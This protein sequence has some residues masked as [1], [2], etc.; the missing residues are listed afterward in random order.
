[1]E[2]A[3]VEK[4]PLSASLKEVIQADTLSR[5]LAKVKPVVPGKHNPGGMDGKP[6][7]SA[8]TGKMA[9]EAKAALDT[10]SD[11]AY[12]GMLTNLAIRSMDAEQTLL[13][14]G[15]QFTL[16]MSMGKDQQVIWC[17]AKLNDWVRHWTEKGKAFDALSFRF[18]QTNGDVQGHQ[19]HGRQGFIT[20]FFCGL[21]LYPDQADLLQKR[22]GN[23]K[24]SKASKRLSKAVRTYN[25]HLEVIEYDRKVRNG[26]IDPNAEPEPKVKAEG[27]GEAGDEERADVP[28]DETQSERFQKP[29]TPGQ[30]YRAMYF[31]AGDRKVTLTG[32]KVLYYRDVLH[33][34]CV[35][36][37]G[38]KLETIVKWES[39][40]PESS[41]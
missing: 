16:Y 38:A 25:E 30:F 6:I 11:S 8:A 33:A 9:K 3:I 34:L 39:E 22:L 29:N 28:V 21:T 40:A 1:M 10:A 12:Q 35:E 13:E 32:G 18:I 20:A 36:V 7:S 31:A 2:T 41:K 26:E 37:S 27:E 23:S 5:D 17:V 19:I 4:E 24:D 14:I 15:Q